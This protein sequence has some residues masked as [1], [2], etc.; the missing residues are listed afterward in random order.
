MP[1]LFLWLILTAKAYALEFKSADYYRM[2]KALGQIESGN[3]P[4]ARNKKTSASGKYQFMRAWD[5]WFKDT[6]GKT[7]TETVP[8]KSATDVAEFGREQDRL[9]DAY[10]QYRVQPWLKRN[11]A[12]GRAK[13]FSDSDLV[14]IYHRQGEG[15]ATRFLKTGKDPFKGRYS[16]PH[17]LTHVKRMRSAMTTTSLARR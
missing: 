2:R 12:K 15:G 9:F 13:G 7:W 3:D 16:N 1:I 5:G 4:T 11:R 6:V 8:K 10:Y 17:L 14:A